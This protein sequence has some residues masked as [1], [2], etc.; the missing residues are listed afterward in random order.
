MRMRVR[1][2]TVTRTWSHDLRPRVSV[3]SD[4]GLKEIFCTQMQSAEPTVH[5]CTR[6]MRSRLKSPPRD[7]NI[8][9]LGKLQQFGSGGRTDARITNWILA[10][11]H[12]P[13]K[14]VPAP[15]CSGLSAI[16]QLRFSPPRL[17][18]FYSS[19]LPARVTWKPVWDLDHGD[20]C[21]DV[22][23]CPGCSAALSVVA[24]AL[25]DAFQG[26]DSLLSDSPTAS[27]VVPPRSTSAGRRAG[28]SSMMWWSVFAIS[29]VFPSVS[30]LSN[31][32]WTS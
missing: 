3:D 24:H 25:I 23:G 17:T 26:L 30:L 15:R 16:S 22:D 18:R 31:M 29:P 20:L 11:N 4:D 6:S 12:A 7:I 14:P 13:W 10:A 1:Q 5:A 28:A 21:L 2:G 19:M 32:E 8:H 27:S 9:C